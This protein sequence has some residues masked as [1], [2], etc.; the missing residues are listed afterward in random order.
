MAAAIEA[1]GGTLVVVDVTGSVVV[2]VV[3]DEDEF[4]HAVS[5]IA[6]TAITTAPN[7]RT[8]SSSHRSRSPGVRVTLCSTSRLTWI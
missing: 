6:M 7:L 4:V 1:R 2:E 3:G 5:N 8:F